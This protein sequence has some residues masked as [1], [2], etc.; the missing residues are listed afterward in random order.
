MGRM[1]IVPG[2]CTTRRLYYCVFVLPTDMGSTEEA[3][4]KH[5]GNHLS[6]ILLTQEIPIHALENRKIAYS[7]PLDTEISYLSPRE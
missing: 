5:Y 6:M 1:T 7:R 3:V 4:P 2:F